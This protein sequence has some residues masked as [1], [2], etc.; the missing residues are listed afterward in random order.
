MAAALPA[1][2][3]VP[4]PLVRSLAGEETTESLSNSRVVNFPE[5]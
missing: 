3:Y 1:I 4:A 5:I 2:R